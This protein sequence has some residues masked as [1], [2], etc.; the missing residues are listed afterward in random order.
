[1]SYVG[2]SGVNAEQQDQVEAAFYDAFR[3][4][5]DEVIGFL[6]IKATEKTQWQDVE[7]KY[8]RQW[9]PVG[10]EISE[11]YVNGCSEVFPALQI[12]LGNLDPESSTKFLQRLYERTNHFRWLAFQFD[13]LDWMEDGGQGERILDFVNRMRH[14]GTTI[15]QCY[16]DLMERYQP[17]QIVRR[18]KRLQS[19]GLVN[20]V[21]FDASHGTGKEMDPEALR[22][23]IGTAYEALDLEELGV[24]VAGGLD[25]PTVRRHM[26]GL[27]DEFPDLSWDAEGKLHYRDKENGGA[28]NMEVV[29]DYLKASAEVLPPR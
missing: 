11:V 5:R 4:H 9:Y 17:Y 22:P 3:G 27:L 25:G 1:M 24:G 29:E 7:N 10:E 8:G 15:L 21:L 28:L 26:P 12:Y 20:F 19:N 6:G 14:T 23:F 16:G 2:V 18:L 13:R